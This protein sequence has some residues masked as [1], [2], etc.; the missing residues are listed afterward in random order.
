[1]GLLNENLSTS[2]PPKVKKEASSCCFKVVWHLPLG[3]LG[4]SSKAEKDTPTV[5]QE[6]RAPSSNGSI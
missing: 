1:M 6:A 4:V 5:I 3:E 2:S